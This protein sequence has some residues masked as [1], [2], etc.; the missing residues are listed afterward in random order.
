MLASRAKRHVFTKKISISSLGGDQFDDW[1]VGPQFEPLTFISLLALA[2]PE[3]GLFAP[4]HVPTDGLCSAEDP[5][6]EFV[7][8]LKISVPRSSGDRFDD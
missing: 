3:R 2:A 6:C 8:A 4:A 1:V 5:V 7:S